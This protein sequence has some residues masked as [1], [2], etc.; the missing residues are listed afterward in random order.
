MTVYETK[1]GG[2]KRKKP[3]RRVAFSFLKDYNSPNTSFTVSTTA[4]QWHIRKYC[5]LL[6]AFS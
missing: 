4:M 2:D 1:D 5:K 6:G 3:R